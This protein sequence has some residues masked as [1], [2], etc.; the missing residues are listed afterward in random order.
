M[1]VE[2]C[3]ESVGTGA[4]FG[5]PRQA[6]RLALRTQHVIDASARPRGGSARLHFGELPGFGQT[7]D[8]SLAD[9]GS[10]SG[11][12][13]VADRARGG[14]LVQKGSCAKPSRSRTT[15]RTAP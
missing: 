14:V 10:T 9:D 4:G 7:L 1:S 3:I 6:L 15:L 13:V 8:P 12:A 5:I 2:V 11:E